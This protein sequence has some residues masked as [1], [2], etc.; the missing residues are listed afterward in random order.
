VSFYPPQ[1]PIDWYKTQVSAVRGWLLAIRAMAWSQIV[2]YNH[3]YYKYL[4]L[5]LI[6][7]HFNSIHG[8]LSCVRMRAILFFQVCYTFNLEAESTAPEVHQFG[9][10]KL[11]E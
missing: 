3:H 8:A 9:T 1:R 11:R 10:S 7:R 4:P 6:M 5:I 2:C